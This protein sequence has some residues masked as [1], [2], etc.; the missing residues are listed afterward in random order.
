MNRY[1]L[2]RYVC[3]C[4][5]NSLSLKI[6]TRSDLK[7]F[8]WLIILLWISVFF[9]FFKICRYDQTC[10]SDI[11]IIKHASGWVVDG[12]WWWWGMRVT[13]LQCWDLYLAPL[14]PTLSTIVSIPIVAELGPACCLL[15]PWLVRRG[16]GKC[17]HNVYTEYRGVKRWQKCP[18][19]C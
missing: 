16:P 3:R 7:Q 8:V 18:N 5:C 17:G 6:A 15:T 13:L 11:D 4:K 10:A 12:G 14:C 9:H 1:T 2:C 19:V